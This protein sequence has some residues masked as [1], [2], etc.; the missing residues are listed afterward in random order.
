MMSHDQRGFSL[1]E[2]IV[3]TIVATVAVIGLAYSFG[4]GR[5]FIDRFETG[6]VALAIVQAKMESLTVVPPGDPELALGTHP[7]SPIP[8]VWQGRQVGSESWTVAAFDDPGVA[9]S[10]DLRRV[11]VRVMWRVGALN[12][13]VLISRLFPRP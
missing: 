8:F 13:T 5:A 11:T 2:V 9:G 10:D 7:S 4:M 3:A 1:M 6:R 12:D